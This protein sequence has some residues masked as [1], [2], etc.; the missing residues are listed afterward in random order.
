MTDPSYIFCPKMKDLVMN[1]VCA[2]LQSHVAKEKLKSY[3]HCIRE[4]YKPKQ[5]D[6]LMFLNFRVIINLCIYVYK[7]EAL[8]Q[9]YKP[10]LHY[11]EI[12]TLCIYLFRFL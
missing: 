2:M 7:N 1:C 12:S 5:K 9:K 3:V 6:N 4:M 8:P 10:F 11:C